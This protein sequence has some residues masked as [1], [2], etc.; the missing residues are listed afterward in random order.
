MAAISTV[1]AA[2]SAAGEKLQLAAETS[3]DYQTQEASVWLCSDTEGVVV[4]DITNHT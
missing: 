4:A 1:T 3:L 2:A